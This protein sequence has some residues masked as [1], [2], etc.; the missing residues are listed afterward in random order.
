MLPA[1]GIS[2]RADLLLIEFLARAVSI[3][4]GNKTF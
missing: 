4:G 1:M 2:V 3:A